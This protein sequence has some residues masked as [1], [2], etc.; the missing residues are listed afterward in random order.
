MTYLLFLYIYQMNYII[1][2]SQQTQKGAVPINL[3][4]NPFLRRFP[5]TAINASTTINP[6]FFTQVKNAGASGITWLGDTASKLRVSGGEFFGKVWDAVS[7]FFSNVVAKLAIGL[8]AVRD[9]GISAFGRT[10]EAFTALPKAGQIGVVAAVVLAV[11]GIVYYFSRKSPE[12]PVVSTATVAPDAAAAAA[13]TATTTTAAPTSDATTPVAT[14]TPAS[15]A[16]APLAATAAPAG[17]AP[18]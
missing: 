11:V 3:Q 9:F 5:M 14:T 18:Q 13:N 15:D 1:F 8:R 12:A 17:V 7:T 10:K 4:K 16:T 2:R 6:S